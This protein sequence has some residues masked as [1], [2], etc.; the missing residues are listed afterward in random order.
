MKSMKNNDIF[1]LATQV[2]S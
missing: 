1:N 2:K